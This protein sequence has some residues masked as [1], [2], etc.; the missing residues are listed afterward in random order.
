MTQQV[1]KRAIIGSWMKY[2]CLSQVCST[3]R[4]VQNVKLTLRSP[5]LF[6]LKCV[7][8]A[9]CMEKLLCWFWESI[10]C[11]VSVL[12][13]LISHQLNSYQFGFWQ[14][15]ATN[16]DP[17]ATGGTLASEYLMSQLHQAIKN[18]TWLFMSWMKSGDVTP[19]VT[20]EEYFLR[21]RRLV[22]MHCIRAFCIL[23]TPHTW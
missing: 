6:Y 5:S 1:D 13:L 3:S 16:A 11:F 19:S 7:T 21:D 14:V 18:Q 22:S 20:L 2:L 23:N 4:P 15:T 9:S 12:I 8:Q 10:C 17:R